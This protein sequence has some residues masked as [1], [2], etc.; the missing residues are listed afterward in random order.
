M[1]FFNLGRNC[2]SGAPHTNQF[3]I[4]FNIVK[5]NIVETTFILVVSQTDVNLVVTV[6]K[7]SRIVPDD[8]I[9]TI[10]F[11]PDWNR[12]PKDTVLI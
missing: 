11:R 4:S 2:V 1:S 3:T 7:T 12:Y 6:V 8:I 9:L 5:M 10:L